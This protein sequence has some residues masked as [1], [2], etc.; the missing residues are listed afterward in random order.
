MARLS[1][2]KQGNFTGAYG[3][4]SPH[5]YTLCKPHLGRCDS[6]P[7]STSPRDTGTGGECSSALQSWH[8]LVALGSALIFSGSRP[9]PVACPVFVRWAS[10]WG[11][12]LAPALGRLLGLLGLCSGAF[13]SVLC[14]YT[15]ST[16][17]RQNC[18]II[19]K[20]NLKKFFRLSG[21]LWGAFCLCMNLY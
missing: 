1:H 14:P 15:I 11:L 18:D 8:N 16:L 5:I 7:V 4:R 17:Q 13:A 10:V 12:F 9:R 20:K 21:A 19:S 3:Q 6:P 2:A